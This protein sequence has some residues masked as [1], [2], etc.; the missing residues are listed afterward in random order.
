MVGVGGSVTSGPTAAEVSANNDEEDSW[1]V[2]AFF[3]ITVVFFVVLAC[4]IVYFLYTRPSGRKK[5]TETKM[6]LENSGR[7]IEMGRT[8]TT[9]GPTPDTKAEPTPPLQ[10]NKTDGFESSDEV[11]F[12]MSPMPDEDE[13]G[14][15]PQDGGPD[16]DDLPPDSPALIVPGIQPGGAGMEGE[17]LQPEGVRGES[18]PE[19]GVAEEGKE[20]ILMD[21][22]R[23]LKQQLA[24]SKKRG[25]PRD[26]EG[27]EGEEGF[28]RELSDYVLPAADETPGSPRLGDILRKKEATGNT[29]D[30][31]KSTSPGGEGLI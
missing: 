14:R 4:F 13:P 20:E 15:P 27:E 22:I 9:Q 16:E 17:V 12:M 28:S 3:Y 23:R 6:T 29:Y 18:L 10:Q 25:D 11:D 1:S 5:D 2:Q 7:T 8:P 21:E 19:E 30:L 24:R 31:G 26:V